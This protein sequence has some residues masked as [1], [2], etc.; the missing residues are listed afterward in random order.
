MSRAKFTEEVFGTGHEE[1]KALAV[2]YE[3]Q[4]RAMGRAGFT[5]KSVAPKPGE[6]FAIIRMANGSG[7][8][9]HVAAVVASD[10]DTVVTVEA[11]AGGSATDPFERPQTQGIVDM[12]ATSGPP[13]DAADSFHL[14]YRDAYRNLRKNQPG[15][16]PITVVLELIDAPRTGG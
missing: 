7:N 14:R 6:A 1:N 3:E 16:D 2:R 8:P 11:D 4:L 12:Y 9:Y 13:R 5:G 15:P 10:Q